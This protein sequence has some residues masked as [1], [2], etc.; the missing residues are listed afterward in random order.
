LC[1]AAFTWLLISNSDL[2]ATSTVFTI[3]F[4]TS[5]GVWAQKKGHDVV[6]LPI[7][8]MIGSFA[9]EKFLIAYQLWS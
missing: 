8:L 5:I 9:I 4:F 2:T 6:A 7:S 1:V 3:V